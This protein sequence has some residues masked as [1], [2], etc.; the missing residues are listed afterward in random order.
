MS[1][2]SRQEGDHKTGTS[3]NAVL[4]KGLVVRTR[5]QGGDEARFQVWEILP[6]I[7][8]ERDFDYPPDYLRTSVQLHH[9]ES[10][11]PLTLTPASS[12]PGYLVC[13]AAQ[14]G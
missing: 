14:R 6:F 4:W 10:N 13:I 7:I 3:C 12:P 8:M 11:F 5:R 2:R 9:D 1:T